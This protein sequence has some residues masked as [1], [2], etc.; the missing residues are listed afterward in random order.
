M[1]MPFQKCDGCMPCRARCAVAAVAATVAALG[2]YP[3]IAGHAFQQMVSKLWGQLIS[4]SLCFSLALHC[5]CSLHYP[6]VYSSSVPI[7]NQLPVKP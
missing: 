3:P 5:I 2:D 1:R 6:A 4:Y 7:V